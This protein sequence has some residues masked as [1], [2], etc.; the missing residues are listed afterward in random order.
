MKYHIFVLVWASLFSLALSRPLNIGDLLKEILENLKKHGGGG[1]SGG[2]PQC[3]NITNSLPAPGLADG[4][5]SIIAA[6]GLKSPRGM[7]FDSKGRLLIVDRGVGIKQ[8]T[9]DDCGLL[10]DS[11]TIVADISLNHGIDISG[12]GKTLFASNSDAAF[13]WTYNPNSGK[14][15]KKVTLVTGMDS[16]DHVTRSLMV[17]SA[18][19]NLLVISVGSNANIDNGTTEYSSGRSQI[20]GFMWKQIIASKKSVVFKE[21]GVNL[22]WGL[23]NSVGITEDPAGN[24]WSVEN[25]ADNVERDDID[26]H[27]NNPGEELNFH[28][29]L[30]DLTTPRPNYGYPRCLTAWDP[31]AVSTWTVKRGEQFA[32]NPTVNFTDETCNTDY[33][34]PR[35]AFPAHSAPL[36]IRFTAGADAIV[37]FHGSWNRQPPTGYQLVS[38]PFDPMTGQPVASSDSDAGFKP[39]MWNKDLTQCPGK[40]FRPTSIAISPLGALYMTSDS[41]GEVYRLT[42]GTST[43]PTSPQNPTKPW[44]W[45][46]WLPWPLNN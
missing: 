21:S 24:M 43:G 46:S 1:G 25:S 23:R 33:E 27:T 7:T 36:D 3:K 12:D 26:I 9:V 19:P 8:F 18:N 32:V 14:V 40:C 5:Q 4:Y 34:P 41:T 16:T 30:L 37:T 39:I 20:R 10:T 17:P 44:W 29:S 15:S 38:I 42:R 2:T 28:G 6:K 22:G 45:P 31:S 35:L 13:A 11:E